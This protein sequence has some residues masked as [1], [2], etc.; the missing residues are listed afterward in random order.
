MAWDEEGRE[1]GVHDR[2]WSDCKLL[3]GW[4]RW[5]RCVHSFPSSASTSISPSL[6]PS[7]YIRPSGSLAA[8]RKSLPIKSS[9]RGLILMLLMAATGKTGGGDPPFCCNSR[10]DAKISFPASLAESETDFLFS[11][12]CSV[13][14]AAIILSSRCDTRNFLTIPSL[15]PLSL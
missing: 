6:L 3:M 7:S 5:A 11:S 12:F 14:H 2:G 4:K 13:I 9:G 10:E 1:N 8:H 15:H